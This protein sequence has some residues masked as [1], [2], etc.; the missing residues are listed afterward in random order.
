MIL[1]GSTGL[2]PPVIPSRTTLHGIHCAAL[3]MKAIITGAV[4]RLRGIEV[5][6]YRGGLLESRIKGTG[7]DTG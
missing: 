4:A 7:M 5:L 6:R 2:D 1:N 3:R